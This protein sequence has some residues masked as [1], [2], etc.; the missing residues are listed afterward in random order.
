MSLDKMT[1]PQID[2]RISVGNIMVALG[3][4]VSVAMAWA[5]L[6]GRADAMRAEINANK[7]AIRSTR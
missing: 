1:G 6:S 2:N 5:N 7:A 3:M 4:V